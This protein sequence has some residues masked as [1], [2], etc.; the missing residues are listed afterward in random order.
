MGVFGGC[1]ETR[2]RQE[3]QVGGAVTEMNKVQLYAYF[4]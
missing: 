3:R 1:T 4:L 2:E